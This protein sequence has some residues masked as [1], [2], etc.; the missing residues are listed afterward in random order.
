MEIYGQDN[1]DELFVVK[2][3]KRTGKNTNHYKSNQGL[4]TCKVCSDHRQPRKR[5]LGTVKY[6]KG[7]NGLF[8]GDITKVERK[9]VDQLLK[10]V[11]K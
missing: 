7:L 1:N 11:F 4:C 3:C 8:K 10:G 5:K 2:K 6:P 9:T